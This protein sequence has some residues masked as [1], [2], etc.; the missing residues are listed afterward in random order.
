MSDVAIMCY[1]MSIDAMLPEKN[2]EAAG[3]DL[4]S[5]EDVEIYPENRHPISTGLVVFPEKMGYF[6][7]IEARSGLAVNHGIF[8]PCGVIDPDY[9]GELKVVLANSGSRP[10]QIK[11]GQ[12]IAQFLV[13]PL[14]R[15]DIIEISSLNTATATERGSKGFGSSG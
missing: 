6:L 2:Y 14:L 5:N 15:T 1:K 3:W 13:L 8:C 4:F 10:I 7:K 9:R 11:K 12:K